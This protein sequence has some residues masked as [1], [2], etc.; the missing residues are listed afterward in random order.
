MAERKTRRSH[1]RGKTGRRGRRRGI[2]G[3]WLP[4]LVLVAVAYFYYRPIASWMHTRSA[5]AHRETQVASL[6]RQKAELEK[7]VTRATSLAALRRRARRIGLVQQG[8][9]LFIVKGIPGWRRAHAH[10]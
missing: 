7:A 10:P 9:Q 6:Q 5:L 1:A 4:I 3:R 2:I 8:E